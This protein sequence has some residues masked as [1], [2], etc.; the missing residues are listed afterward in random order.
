MEIIE[1]PD[2]LSSLLQQVCRFLCLPG[3]TTGCIVG[4]PMSVAPPRKNSCLSSSFCNVLLSSSSL[5]T[6]MAC[7]RYQ[8][9]SILFLCA[10]F[11]NHVRDHCF[12]AVAS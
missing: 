12:D 10:Q 5:E 11:F 8:I 6:D 3:K 7:Q 1:V 4:F 2:E 9:F